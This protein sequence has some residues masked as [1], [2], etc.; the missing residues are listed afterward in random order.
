MG[1]EPER[2]VDYA[3]YTALKLSLADRILTVT[4][5][6]PGRRNALTPAMS[7]EL[8][9]VWADIWDDPAVAVVIL[10][11]E[12]ESFCSGADVA[13][14][15][16]EGAAQPDTVP[17]NITTRIARRHVMGIVDCEKP[18]LAKVRGPAFGAGVNLA[19]ACDMV[20]AA[21][22]AKFC[23]PHV[24]VGLAAGD[25]GVL[26]WPLA[27]GF[28]RAKEYLMTGD[29]VPAEEAERIGLINRV[30]ADDALDAHVQAMAEKLRDLPP[31]A[32]NYTK[33]GLNTALKQ[34]T[35]A[36]FET[37]LAYEVYT[38]GTADHR[39]AMAA[40]AERRKGRFTGR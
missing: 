10:T 13:A 37:S 39:E 34:M 15:A 25:G 5:S 29:P 3:G 21:P 12:G 1:Y 32:V 24:K 33:T 6:N 35:Q 28:H 26:L 22:S 19:L 36:G 14:L 9:H 27:I 40:F 17:L 30:I 23:D 20:F 31:H 8:A 16:G 11:G 38:M 2:T 18:V 4:L 7:V